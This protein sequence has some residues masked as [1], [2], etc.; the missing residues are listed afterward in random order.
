MIDNYLIESE[1]TEKAF[2][3]TLE[4]IAFEMIESIGIEISMKIL[5]EKSSTLKKG[6][7]SARCQFHQHFM[8]SR[9]FCTKK[10]KT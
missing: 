2:E 8:S 7:F 4:E 10:P 5:M 9:Y 1:K 3:I 6:T